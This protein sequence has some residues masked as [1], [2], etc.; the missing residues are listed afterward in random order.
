MTIKGR[1]LVEGRALGRILYSERPISFYGGVDPHTGIVVE[2]DHPLNGV[3]VSG[4]ILI[5]P[6]GK[7]STVGSYVL[8]R[9]K[10]RGLA[11]SGI[12]NVESEP[13]IVVGCEISSI[14]LMDKPE[15]RLSKD[16]D[17]CMGELI[18][19]RDTAILRVFE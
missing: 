5:F 8:L 6:Y 14:P 13:I 12:V 11:P 1:P 17:G 4:K 15:V 16:M 19:E 2:R 9:L 18:V 3:S 10:M 7:G